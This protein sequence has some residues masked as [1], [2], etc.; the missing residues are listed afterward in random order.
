MDLEMAC[1][2]RYSHESKY[3]GSGVARPLVVFF[4]RLPL[5]LEN[6]AQVFGNLPA[7]TGS[8]K[9]LEARFRE[10]HLYAA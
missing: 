10:H 3:L 8:Q 7:I 2:F 1:S 9:S 6:V 4:R 5:D